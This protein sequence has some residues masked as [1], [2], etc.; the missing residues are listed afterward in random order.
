MNYVSSEVAVGFENAFEV[1]ANNPE[2]INNNG[3]FNW[4]FIDADLCI[5]GWMD[6]LGDNLYFKFF[7]EM[8]NV[9]SEN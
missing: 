1:A 9:V 6:I 8:I 4:N 2:N 3:S 7:D 5:D